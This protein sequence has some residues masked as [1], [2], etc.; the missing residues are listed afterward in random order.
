MLA[1]TCETRPDTSFAQHW[2]EREEF[3][4]PLDHECFDD[5]ASFFGGFWDITRRRLMGICHI[6]TVLIPF[7]IVVEFKSHIKVCRYLW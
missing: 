2:L 3:R 1:S 5:L 4:I 6:G 7:E